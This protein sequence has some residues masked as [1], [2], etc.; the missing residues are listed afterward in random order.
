M[1]FSIRT[2]LASLIIASLLFSTFTIV[3][4]APQT[5]AKKALLRNTLT[6][7]QYLVTQESATE[8]PFENAYWDNH[9]DGIYVDIVDGAPLFSSKDKYDSGTGWPTFSKPIK[10]F[11]I[12]KVKDRSI[13]EE[14]V[15]IR[16]RKANSHLGHLFMDGPKEY[17]YVR[18]CMNSA[19][20][21]FIPVADLEKEGYGKY[22]SLFEMK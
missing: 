8:N 11:A 19:A 4:A 2:S 13:A 22:K 12:R 21:R 6:N 14:R 16:S 15:E 10:A 7:V 17:G 3:S 20:F 5:P 18:Y 1:L 9:A